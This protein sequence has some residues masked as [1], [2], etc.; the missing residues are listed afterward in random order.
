METLNSDCILDSI[1]KYVAVLKTT[2]KKYFFATQ[3]NALL[4][5]AETYTSDTEQFEFFDIKFSHKRQL[6]FK[7]ITDIYFVSFP[8]EFSPAFANYADDENDIFLEMSK[9]FISKIKNLDKNMFKYTIDEETHTIILNL[10]RYNDILKYYDIS[11]DS[12]D[13]IILLFDEGIT[14]S[15][16]DTYK[17][18]IF[19]SKGELKLTLS[20]T[21]I[22]SFFDRKTQEYI[23]EDSDSESRFNKLKAL[24]THLLNLSKEKSVIHLLEEKETAIKDLIGIEKNYVI[25]HFDAEVERVKTLDIEKELTYIDN[26]NDLIM[27][28]PY[29][30]DLTV[31]EYVV[32]LSP[33]KNKN[34]GIVIHSVANTP[35]FNLYKV[36]KEYIKHPISLR[37]FEFLKTSEVN[38]EVKEELISKK[39]LIFEKKR[40]EIFEFLNSELNSTS[41]EEIKSDILN[42]KNEINGSIETY[43]TE[44]STESTIR[45]ILRYWPVYLYP[46]PEELVVE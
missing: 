23:L 29:S 13:R 27:Y 30:S 40:D 35:F 20:S 18:K 22:L 14:S 39:L 12:I 8:D 3:N 38:K 44:I 19:G 31:G 5:R 4:D 10:L 37:T 36:F 46:I 45:E 15:F 41:I 34:S 21:L 7:N 16:I 32:T 24:Y 42:L 28:W 11:L 25:Q 6:Y 2:D 33:E 26:E 1:K 43:K 17:D 9:Q